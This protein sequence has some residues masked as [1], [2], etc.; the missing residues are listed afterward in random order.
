MFI[1]CHA[2][3][4]KTEVGLINVLKHNSRED[5]DR[6]N[7]PDWI[8]KDWSPDSIHK[9]GEPWAAALEKRRAA[10]KGLKRKPQKNAAAA[11]EFNISASEGFKD[12]GRYFRNVRSYLVNKYGA[13]NLLSWA[14]HTDENTPHVHAVFAPII[15]DKKGERKYSSSEF[16]GGR[17]GLQRLQTEMFW[18]CGAAV[19]LDRGVEGSRARHSDAKDFARQKKLVEQR[20]RIVATREQVVNEN[21]QRLDDWKEFASEKNVAE[22]LAW[23]QKGMSGA[24]SPN[25]VREFCAR[26]GKIVGG[27]HAQL[28]ELDQLADVAAMY[29]EKSPEELEDLARTLREKRCSCAQELIEREAAA[30]RKNRGYSG[31][32]R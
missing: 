23:A 28:R 8:N 1:V 26:A 29:R 12:W 7:P 30:A 17:G 19:G 27:L 22:F 10:L 15:K 9:D 5:V 24:L 11:I 32:S 14:V 16:L 6:Q 20:E 4:I 31:R 18:Y 21:A 2:R 3:K 25:Y 13:E